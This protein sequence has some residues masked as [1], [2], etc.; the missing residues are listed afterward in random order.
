MLDVLTIDEI[1]ICCCENEIDLDDDT[2]KG[3]GSELNQGELR[4][5]LDRVRNRILTSILR[6][7]SVIKISK[8]RDNTLDDNLSW[9]HLYTH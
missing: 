4:K 2:V 7:S 8:L 9:A 6:S 5:Y 3:L 1:G